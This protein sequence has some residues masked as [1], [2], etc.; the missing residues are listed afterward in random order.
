MDANVLLAGRRKGRGVWW[1]FRI[2]AQGLLRQ[3]RF[4]VVLKYQDQADI[5]DSSMN[6]F[7]PSGRVIA[8]H[9]YHAISRDL[10]ARVGEPMQSV[11]ELTLQWA[12]TEYRFY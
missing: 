9:S 4:A 12:W 5:L 7:G 3:L 1:L 10:D 6:S 11:L 2:S 8:F